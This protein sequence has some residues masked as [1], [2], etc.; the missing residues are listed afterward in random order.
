MVVVRKAL[1]PYLYE[2]SNKVMCN[3]HDR[4]KGKFIVFCMSQN[5]ITKKV[6]QLKSSKPTVL[7]IL[8]NT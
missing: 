1:I 7:E 8:P 2:Q 4:P 5:W 3:N 6:I